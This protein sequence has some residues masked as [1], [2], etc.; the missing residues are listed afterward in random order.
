ML[1]PPVLLICIVLTF[2]LCVL[3]WVKLHSVSRLYRSLRQNERI[4]IEDALK[5]LYDCEYHG[6]TATLQSL[7]GVLQ[8]DADRVV[9]LTARLEAMEL[10][11]CEEAGLRLTDEGR[12]N[13]LRM[14]RIHRLWE[15]YLAQRTGLP[16]SH[17]HYEA[18]RREH[19]TSPEQVERIAHETGNPRFDPH[20]D[21]IPTPDGELPEHRGSPLS[22]HPAGS[23][24]TVV[25]VEDEPEAVYAQLR[26]KGVTVNQQVNL[27]D[28]SSEGVRLE[29]D[30][31]EQTMAPVVAANVWVV[32]HTTDAP[33]R[34]VERLSSLLVG[35]SRRVVGL[36]PRC[37]GIQR[38][39]FLDLGLVPGTKV[40]SVMQSPAGDPTGYRIRGAVIAL[41]SEQAN[42]I[43]I[44]PRR[45][46]P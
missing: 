35:E 16:E 34:P 45:V 46:E 37:Q 31:Q 18:D 2:A 25:H 6:S 5:H 20:G 28:R 40:T 17:W 11:R 26:E 23:S 27:L 29:I 10:L 8:T 19:T 43:Q 24:L 41:R 15:T 33:R 7:A 21:P 3:L 22:D 39:R 44:E 1:S 12:R 32:P 4:V 36:S 30:G 14:I 38:Q 42:M 13:A 9:D